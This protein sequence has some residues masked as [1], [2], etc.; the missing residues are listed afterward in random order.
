M[1]CLTHAEKVIG[2]C[3]FEGENYGTSGAK[4]S[5]VFQKHTDE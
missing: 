2:R 4:H 5:I 3:G 1:K